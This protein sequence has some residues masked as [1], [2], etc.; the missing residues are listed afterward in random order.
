MSFNL[1]YPNPNDGD[2][3]WE[4]RREL[5]VETIRRSDP[6]VFGTQEMF[7]SQAAF[8][9]ERL[10]QYQWLGVSRRGNHEDEHM[11]VFYKRGKL[12][13]IESGSFESSL[14]ISPTISK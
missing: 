9:I 10:P 7:D 14:A 6:D 4:N 1:R 2:N 5:V 13:P 3:V 12:F 8:I 11:G